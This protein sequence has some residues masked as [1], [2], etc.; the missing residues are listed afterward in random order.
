MTRFCHDP[1][2]LIITLVVTMIIAMLLGMGMPTTA[3]YVMA[4]A[5]AAR[6][7]LARSEAFGRTSVRILLRSALVGDST[8]LRRGLYRSRQRS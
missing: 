3:S 1:G 6:Y 4:S 7:G 2:T 5:V 8:G